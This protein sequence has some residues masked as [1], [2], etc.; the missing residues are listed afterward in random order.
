MFLKSFNHLT[1]LLITDIINISHVRF[2]HVFEN[3][4]FTF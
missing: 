4:V 2:P 1:V 3:H